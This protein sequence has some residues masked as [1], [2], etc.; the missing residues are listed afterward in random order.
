MR[1]W[2]FLTVAFIW[3]G[4]LFSL[5]V[6]AGPDGYKVEA[7]GACEGKTL[8]DPIRQSLQPQGARLLDA[9]GTALAEFWL[10]RSLPAKSGASG[11]SKLSEG[12]LVGVLNLPAPSSDFRGQAIKPGLYTLRY[13]QIPSDGNHTGAAPSTDFL[14]LIP[15]AA[16]KDLDAQPKFDEVV[17]LSRQASGT[18]HPAVFMLTT[19][20]GGAVPALQGQQ[21]IWAVTLKTQTADAKEPNFPV[22]L[23][24][25]G[26]AEG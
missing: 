4:L 13:V 24:L 15:A 23:V 22:A 11:Y 1:R 14:A 10:R 7:A 19:P 21:G 6:W 25:L 9:K 20:A 12:T 2:I 16:D 5:S 3:A 18:N 26:K 17:K 8:A